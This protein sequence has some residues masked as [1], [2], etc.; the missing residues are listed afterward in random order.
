MIDRNYA[1]RRVG[2][3]EGDSGVVEGTVLVIDWDRVVGVRGVAALLL[4]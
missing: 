1:E 2:E 4:D 3:G